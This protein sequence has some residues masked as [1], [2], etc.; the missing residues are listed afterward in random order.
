[1]SMRIVASFTYLVVGVLAVAYYRRSPHLVAR[2]DWYETLGVANGW[3][4]VAYLVL[5]TWALPDYFHIP[6]VYPDPATVTSI[7]L[8]FWSGHVAYSR[9]KARVPSAAPTAAV[10][11]IE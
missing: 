4:S 8:A 9:N 11:G 6:A 7:L 1:M 2:L 3:G 10:E 5:F